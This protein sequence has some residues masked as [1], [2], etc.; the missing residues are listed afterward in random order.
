MVQKMA[1]YAGP[2]Y[3]HEHIRPFPG[4]TLERLVRQARRGVL[5]ATTIVRGPTTH[6]QWRFA[7]ETPGLARHLGVCWSCQSPVTDQSYSCAACGAVQEAEPAPV[8]DAGQALPTGSPLD[9]IQRAVTAAPEFLDTGRPRTGFRLPMPLVI[10]AL[11]AVTVAGLMFVVQQRER[12][13]DVAAERKAAK[14]VNPS[15]GGNLP[16]SSPA[17]T[18]GVRP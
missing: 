14:L 10:F 2:W 9:Q 17:S 12:A 15:S 5:T 7:A 18:S 16:A 3:V 11:V 8:A 4:V 1:G 6:H 13:R